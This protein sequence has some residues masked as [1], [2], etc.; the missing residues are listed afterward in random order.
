[1]SHSVMKKIVLIGFMGTGKST[2]ATILANRLGWNTIDV[3]YEIVQVSGMPISQI[4]EEQGE[5]VFRQ[6]ESDVLHQLLTSD[7]RSLVVATGGGAV[8]QQK[9]R[10]LMLEHSFVVWLQASQ[11]IIIERVKHDT[12]RPLLAGDLEERVAHLL[13]ERKDVYRFAPFSIDTTDLTA[14]EVADAIINEINISQ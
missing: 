14:T 11:E 13:E 7:E 4:F 2:V 1:M 3:D 6:Y 5:A 10:Q 8:L 12:S 9:N